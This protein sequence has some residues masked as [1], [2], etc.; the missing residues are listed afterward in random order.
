MK[1]PLFAALLAIALPSL[2]EPSLV[3]LVRHAEKAAAPADNPALT[4]AGQARA[5]A[6]VEA[7]RDTP[8][9]AVITTGYERTRATARPLAERLGLKPLE[10]NGLPETLAALRQQQGVVLV[11]GHSN[12]LP[13]IAA[14]LGAPEQATLCDNRFGQIWLL[15][16]QAEGPYGLLRLQYGAPDP[17]AQAG[18]S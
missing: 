13:K 3:I 8:V 12:T 15:A 6:L 16:R 14:G 4:A 11:V 9:S 5:Q 7:L 18:C 2:A 1:A 10:L 17:A